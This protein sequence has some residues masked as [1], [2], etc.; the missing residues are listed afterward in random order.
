VPTMTPSMG[1]HRSFHSTLTCVLLIAWSL[2]GASAFVSSSR[3][4][5]QAQKQCRSLIPILSQNSDDQGGEPTTGIPQL[6]P[7][8]DQRTRSGSDTMWTTPSGDKVQPGPFVASRKFQ[9]QYTC[10]VCET[11]NTNSVSRVACE[12]YKAMIWSCSCIIDSESCVNCYVSTHFIF[13]CCR[14]NWCRDCSLQGL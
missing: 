12:Y 4:R 1:Q 9:L 6:P 11:R 13:L 7:C 14:S 10:N 8:Q 5:L 3:S 2:G